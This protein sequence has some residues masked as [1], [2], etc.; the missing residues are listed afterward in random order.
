MH[1]L[2]AVW[3]LLK[4]P[5]PK[6]GQRRTVVH[7]IGFGLAHNCRVDAAGFKVQVRCG[8]FFC[9][10]V[11]EWIHFTIHF[12]GIILPTI[13]LKVYTFGGL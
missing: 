3:G 2:S 13:K 10:L 8:L 5:R 6:L 9:C 1:V 4:I 12:L 11:A 7:S